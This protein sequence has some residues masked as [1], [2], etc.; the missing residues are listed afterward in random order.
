MAIH[1]SI[2]CTH[3]LYMDSHAHEVIVQS[4]LNM[5]ISLQPLVWLLQLQRKGSL[6]SC[7][8]LELWTWRTPALF[9]RAVFC[10]HVDSLSS[11]RVQYTVGISAIPHTSWWVKCRQ[12]LFKWH[13]TF[14]YNSVSYKNIIIKY[15]INS[16]FT[17]VPVWWDYEANCVVIF[18][19]TGANISSNSTDDIRERERE[20]D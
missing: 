6:H 7:S 20:K 16:A 9:N 17:F 5:L 12:N 1:S 15:K 14:Q 3:I 4:R 18:P 8:W 10:F 2:Y 19:S 13:L 11:L